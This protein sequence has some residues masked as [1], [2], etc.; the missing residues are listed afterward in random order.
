MALD[1]LGEVVLTLRHFFGL[2][3]P[4]AAAL[5]HRLRNAAQNPNNDG[6][7]HTTAVVWACGTTLV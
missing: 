7:A 4:L 3:H 1:I 6:T 2:S 5:A